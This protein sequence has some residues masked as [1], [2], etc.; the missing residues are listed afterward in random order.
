MK[1]GS[2]TASDTLIGAENRFGRVETVETG[3]K[4][5]EPSQTAAGAA[6]ASPEGARAVCAE[7]SRGLSRR[8]VTRGS[9][10]ES[11]VGR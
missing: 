3:L 6:G 9:S 11:H 4:T 1:F 5:G 2:E 7:P 10:R 8:C